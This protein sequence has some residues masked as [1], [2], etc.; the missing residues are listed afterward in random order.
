MDQKRSHLTDVRSQLSGH[1]AAAGLV[2]SHSAQRSSWPLPLC[3]WKPMCSFDTWST[4]GP[5]ENIIPISCS[6]GKLVQCCFWRPEFHYYY[7]FNQLIFFFFFFILETRISNYL[8]SLGES[9]TTLLLSLGGG[10]V[11]SFYSDFLKKTFPGLS[12]E[13][14]SILIWY[15]STLH[16]SEYKI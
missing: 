4:S 11:A 5:E 13:L 14:L 16:V 9:T 10:F 15:V 8:A 12:K 3:S 1:P 6:Q 7:F 2:I